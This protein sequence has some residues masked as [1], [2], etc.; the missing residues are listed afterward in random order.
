MPLEPLLTRISGGGYLAHPRYQGCIGHWMVREGAGATVNDLAR[1]GNSNNGAFGTSTNAPLWTGGLFGSALSF[2]NS[3]DYVNCGSDVLFDNITLMTVVAWIFPKS[4]GLAT[5]NTV[6][7]GAI[8]TKG[9]T[10]VGWNLSLSSAD[11]VSVGV[12]FSSCHVTT[13][14]IHRT[15]DGTLLLNVWSHI[16]CTFLRAASNT[17]AT[18]AIIYINGREPTYQT[19]TGGSGNI[20]SDA[21]EEVIIGNN[22]TSALT[23]TFDGY[24]DEVRLY[25]RILARDEIISLYTDPFLEFSPAYR[26]S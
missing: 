1:G 14:M 3:N 23:Q 25:N 22:P 18:N 20:Q 26:R 17:P 6:Y 9:L 7:R 5:V 24:I 11:G 8:V 21:A 19:S 16:A 10:G 15:T 4:A 2:D 13:N 12:K